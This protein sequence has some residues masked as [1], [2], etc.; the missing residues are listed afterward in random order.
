M[1]FENKL[2]EQGKK[3]R[4]LKLLKHDFCDVN[5]DKAIIGPGC[6]GCQHL[7]INSLHIDK[8]NDGCFSLSSKYVVPSGVK[9]I[10]FWACVALSSVLSGDDCDKIQTLTDEN[11]HIETVRICNALNFTQSRRY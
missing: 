9:C 11:C 7:W 3:I 6:I 4:Q 10:T 2:K 5:E 8:F 1:D